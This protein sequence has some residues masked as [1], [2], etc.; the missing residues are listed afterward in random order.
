MPSELNFLRSGNDNR[1]ALKPG[2]ANRAVSCSEPT[3]TG[4]VVTIDGPAGAGKTTAARLLAARLGWEYLDT[5]AGYRVVALALQRTC[6]GSHFEDEQLQQVLSRLRLDIR[7]STVWLD[8]E[9]VSQLIRTPALAELASQLAERPI[10]RD[11]LKAWQQQWAAGRCVVSE[12]RDQGTSVFPSALCK[13]YLEAEPL[14]RAERRYR[15]LR[16]RGVNISREDVLATQQQRDLRD[17]TRAIDRLAPAADA[18]F[19]DSTK[20]SVEAVVDLMESYVQAKLKQ[21][22]PSR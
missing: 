15:E 20:L 22:M 14:E 21:V 5:G 18:I 19:I 12:G 8:G 3:V 9:D 2:S 11:F 6:I 4:W 17:T 1:A 7:G 13:F 16:S 10:V